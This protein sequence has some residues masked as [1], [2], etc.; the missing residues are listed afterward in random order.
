ML[1]PKNFLELCTFRL[2][3]DFNAFYFLNQVAML[4]TEIKA[5]VFVFGAQSFPAITSFTNFLNIS[6]TQPQIT[7]LYYMLTSA[8]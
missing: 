1:G 3:P 6:K 8:K 5:T 4:A 7:E 2:C